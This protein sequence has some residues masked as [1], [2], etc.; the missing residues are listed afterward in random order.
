M[1][2]MLGFWSVIQL[3]LNMLQLV[4]FASVIASWFDADPR[5][6]FVSMIHSITEPIYSLVRPITSRIPGPIDWAPMMILLV[7]VF[8]ER[9]G[10]YYFGH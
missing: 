6:R 8:I 4:I 3:L 10:G 2:I 5:N 1:G 9:A 7:I